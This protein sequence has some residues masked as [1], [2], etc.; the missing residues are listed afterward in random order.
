MPKEIF[1]N[2]IDVKNKVEYIPQPSRIQDID[3]EDGLL[4]DFMIVTSGGE[5]PQALS[6]LEGFS[7][8]SYS[9]NQLYDAID[10]MCEDA[11]ISAA[12]DIYTSVACE[13]NERGQI[14]WAESD[15]PRIN[16]YINHLLD[17]FNVDKFA[18]QWMVS[19]VKYGD[20]YLRLFKKSEDEREEKLAEE[21][22]KKPLNEEL[23]LKVFKDDDPFIE[24]TEMHKNPA[25]V[26]ELQRRGKTVGYIRTHLPETTNLGQ[27]DFLYS[28]SF[29]NRYQFNTNDVDIYP[30]TS[31]VH[32]C[33]VDPNTKYTE[34]VVLGDGIGTET[35]TH[36][37][38]TVRRGRSLLYDAYKIWKTLNLL[39]NAVLLNRITKSSVVKVI[40]VET[41]DMDR[42][43]IKPYLQELSQK[44]EHKVA[45]DV[46]NNMTE[47]ANYSPVENM[48][49]LPTHDGKNAISVSDIGS[50][51]VN[52]QLDDVNYFRKKLFSALGIP[53][54]YLGEDD[55]ESG[56]DSGTN[57]TIKSAQFA[58]KIKRLQNA[59]I[60]A[61]TDE[62]NLILV[63]KNLF[64]YI[65][66]FKI[67]MQEPTTQEE[68]DRR[69]NLTNTISAID[70]QMR[71]LADNGIENPITKLK[72]LK[73]YLTDAGINSDIINLIQDEIDTMEEG[74]QPAEGDDA[75]T[76]DFGSGGSITNDIDFGNEEDL[77][78]FGDEAAVNDAEPVDMDELEAPET[79]EEPPVEDFSQ[80]RG[81]NVLNE[82]TNLPSFNQLGMSYTDVHLN[83]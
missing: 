47:G 55:G 83:H 82:R 39:E 14:V 54:A 80:S 62:I 32:A 63:D 69:D 51:E 28:K 44:I 59:F 37:T 31:F 40:S 41:T 5:N 19:L 70:S 50:A 81:Q 56:F 6:E 45:I 18:Y 4:D 49:F 20:L 33:L 68:Q 53:G 1:D 64:S 2:Q 52:P 30:A 29:L 25:E 58:K 74:A 46:G 75:G 72:A 65:N 22:K 23:V 11:R 36:V 60:Q 79:P 42:T 3:T 43:R 21:K 66:E 76:A 26:F 13:P 73:I 12:V 8:I 7:S 16:T 78:D 27:D 24:Y 15:D 17:T 67:R 77:G 34:E 57:L 71:L 48:I 61:I 9:R 38:Y 35:E 10:S